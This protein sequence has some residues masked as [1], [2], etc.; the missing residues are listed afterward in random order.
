VT[1]GRSARVAVGSVFLINGLGIAT[2][3]PRLPE[4]QQRLGLSDAGLGAALT[5]A[6]FGGLLGSLAA[7]PIVTRLG[8]RRTTLAA[9]TLLGLALFPLG[10]APSGVALAI[11]LAVVGF[12]DAVTD[13]AMNSHGM[14]VQRLYPRP[15]IN[16]FHAAW[17]VGAMT[18]ALLGSLAVALALP[19]EAQMAVLAVLVVVALWVAVGSFLADDATGSLVPGARP[20]LRGLGT[21][22]VV[23]LGTGII[24]GSPADWGAVYLEGSVGARAAVAGLGYTVFAGTMLV[25]RMVA[26]RAVHRFG[27]VAV[28]RVGSLLGVA[29]FL[30]A[31]GV[32][33]VWGVMV[34][35]AIAGIGLAALFPAMFAAGSEVPGLGEGVGIAGTSLLARI[36]FMV[37]P[38]TVGALADATG[39]LRWGLLVAPLAGLA[40]AIAAR[41]VGERHTLEPMEM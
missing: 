38:L 15:I 36:G 6:G 16:G 18:G 14:R 41:A 13:I 7:G 8:S 3:L 34:G 10:I 2:F 35:F 26:D 24:E 9:G 17:S 33:A 5:G 31:L 39:S 27:R 37:G 30:I 28:V 20:L 22:A 29:G 40:V 12:A 32:P 19:L 23:A 25:G 1:Q 11:A 4:I 21:L